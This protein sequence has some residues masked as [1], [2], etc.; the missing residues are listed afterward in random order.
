[1]PLAKLFENIAN[2]IYHS[3][4]SPGGKVKRSIYHALLILGIL[5]ATPN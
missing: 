1:M 3:F 2:K 5:Q 4:N